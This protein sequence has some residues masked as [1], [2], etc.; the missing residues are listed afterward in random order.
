[1]A[2]K[3]LD[4][5]GCRKGLV[6]SHAES[7]EYVPDEGLGY[8]VQDEALIT[9][10]PLSRNVSPGG[11]HGNFIKVPTDEEESR[12]R[13]AAEESQRKREEARKKRE[14]EEAMAKAG[15]ASQEK[16]RGGK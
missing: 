12:M 1:M 8:Y 11:G 15:H 3:R 4:F 2:E 7:L 14:M 9:T 10:V 16:R 6:I 13:K 5:L